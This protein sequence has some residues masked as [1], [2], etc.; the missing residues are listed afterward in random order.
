MTKHNFFNDR[1][2]KFSE[3]LEEAIADEKELIRLD[4][5][6]LDTIK[7]Y[8][9]NMRTL[10]N[11]ISEIER[12]FFGVG[13]DGHQL[14]NDD[15]HAKLR[16]EIYREKRLYKALHLKDPGDITSVVDEV[17][18]H[19]TRYDQV[20]NE[21]LSDKL[22]DLGVFNPTIVDLEWFEFPHANDEARYFPHHKVVKALNEAL[23][24]SNQDLGKFFHKGELYRDLEKLHLKVA[25]GSNTFGED[26]A[27]IVYLGFGTNEPYGLSSKSR[28]G[29]PRYFRADLG[30]ELVEQGAI[31]VSTHPLDLTGMISTDLCNKPFTIYYHEPNPMEV[32]ERVFGGFH[33]KREGL[34][35]EVKPVMQNKSVS[36]FDF[37]PKRIEEFNSWLFTLIDDLS[38]N[39]EGW[40]ATKYD[41][42]YFLHRMGL[43]K[44]S[45]HLT[46]KNHG[47]ALG[48]YVNEDNL[49]GDLFQ[50]CVFPWQRLRVSCAHLGYLLHT[51]SFEPFARGR[52]FN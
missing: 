35:Y 3:I 39:Y 44:I 47:P 33:V 22:M 20:P 12:V 30:E 26:C 51:N 38:H 10:Q 17:G 48:C 24:V 43:D 42:H 9:I 31:T 28:T 4:Y 32:G 52:E 36:S 21:D 25:F 1:S 7:E 27:S 8:L 34:N 41:P 37:T 23:E 46:S 18:V 49:A 5:G 40:A 2:R 14:L 15:S 29:R 11:S 6:D 45:N 19:I 50:V 16:K 13:N